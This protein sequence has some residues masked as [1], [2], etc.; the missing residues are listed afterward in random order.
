MVQKNKHV[1]N[2]SKFNNTVKVN[3]TYN[4]WVQ[5]QYC[6]YNLAHTCT[7]FIVKVSDTKTGITVI[8]NNTRNV[9]RKH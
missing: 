6:Y 7:E 8:I 4:D 2:I 5:S 9:L 3:T 1:S